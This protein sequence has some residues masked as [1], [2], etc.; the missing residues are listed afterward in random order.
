MLSASHSVLLG[1]ALISL[2]YLNTQHWLLH[3][4]NLPTNALVLFTSL[5]EV[6]TT[7]LSLK[8]SSQILVWN[9][10]WLYEEAEMISNHF[11]C[12]ENNYWAN[13]MSRTAL[14]TCWY[15]FRFGA[16]TEKNCVHFRY[17]RLFPSVW[18][19][20]WLNPVCILP[21]WN[22]SK[23]LVLMLSSTIFITFLF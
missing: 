4:T 15:E 19:L 10:W 14:C 21:S 22:F 13:I 1:A 16:L 7:H 18:F 6:S 17:L 8:N 3:D 20:H 9:H 12:S 11:Y 2:L 23:F 5:V